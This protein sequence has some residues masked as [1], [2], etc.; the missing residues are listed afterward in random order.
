MVNK[1]SSGLHNSYFRL[2]RGFTLLE[3]TVVIAIIVFLSTIFLANYRGGEKQFALQRSSH[4]LA[5]DLRT[6]EEMAL[7]SRKFE[8]TFP[9]GGYGIYFRPETNSYILFADCDGEADYDTWGTAQD[10][11]SAAEGQGNSQNEFVKEFFLEEGVKISDILPG[12]PLIITFLPPDPILII[13]YNDTIA[14]SA[15]F[16]LSSGDKTSQVSINAI[17]QIDID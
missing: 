12:F 1:K 2:H 14:N 13:K 6:V 4:K 16:I 7:S 17:G 8:G 9:K 5:Q 3:I 10:C 15:L 11:A